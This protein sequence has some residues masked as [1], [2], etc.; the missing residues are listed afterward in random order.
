M[1]DPDELVE[2][3]TAKVV[4]DGARHSDDIAMVALGLR[5]APRFRLRLD[6]E[7]QLGG[8][9]R[10]RL[11]PWLVDTGATPEEIFD[12]TVACSE[13]FANAIEHPIDAAVSVVDVEGTVSNGELTITIRDYGN[14]REHRLRQEGGLG[15]PL[16]R[17]LMGAVEVKR[18]PE[19]TTVVLRRLLTAALAA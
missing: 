3:I 9:L 6:R 5:P 12:V 18:C 17:S 13:A 11:Q 15:L 16:M 10:N 7:P 1:E 19:G 4:E 2:E 14:W 8:V